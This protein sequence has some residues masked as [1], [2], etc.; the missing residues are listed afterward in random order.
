MI[1]PPFG[2]STSPYLPHYPL[3]YSTPYPSSSSPYM[4]PL[5]TPPSSYC[6]P[7]PTNGGAHP[8]RVHFITGVCNGCKGKY[9]NK[10]GPPSDICLQH[11]EWRTFTPQGS[12]DKQ[13]RF[14]NTYYHC[15]VACVMAVRPTFIPSMVVIPLEVQ[16]RLLPEH[17]YF[18]HVTFGVICHVNN[19]SHMLYV[20]VC[21]YAAPSLRDVNFMWRNANVL[22]D[23]SLE[24]VFN[25]CC[26][27]FPCPRL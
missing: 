12:S 13:S 27:I 9:N 23:L 14:G 26:V 4:P 10:N 1:P 18:I 8:F 21:D 7:D 24:Q 5:S 11:E 3:R 6:G 22:T 25:R 20:K 2:P 17:K 16:S 15:S 19:Y